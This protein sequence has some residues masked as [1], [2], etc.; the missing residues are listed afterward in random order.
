MQSRSLRCAVPALLAVAMAPGPVLAQEVGD[1]VRASLADGPIVGSVSS[2]RSE[3]FELLLRGETR[4][5]IPYRDVE[6]LQWSTG[7]RDTSADGF[8]WGMLLGFTAGLPVSQV[9]DLTGGEGDSADNWFRVS[10]TTGLIG[11]LVG[12]VLDRADDQET[13]TSRP[14]ENVVASLTGSQPVG[15]AP[16]SSVVAVGDTVRVSVLGIATVGRVTAVDEEG[17]E[18]FHDERRSFFDYRLINRVEERVGTRRLWKEGLVYGAMLPLRLVVGCFEASWQSTDPYAG[19][20]VIVCML[21]IPMAWVTSV[22]AAGAGA[23]VGAFIQRPVWAP[24][25]GS[26]GSRGAAG[27]VP[28][29]APGSGIDGRT[30]LELGF[31]IRF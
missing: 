2:V 7:R 19:L 13:W 1:S 4:R 29:V 17:L 11:G 12:L 24:V 18:L 31:R 14:L 26:D 27:L 6:L 5:F 23:L 10:A 8:G 30:S 25:P 28:F 20:G 3:G 22:P 15:S 9:V 21:A 16:S